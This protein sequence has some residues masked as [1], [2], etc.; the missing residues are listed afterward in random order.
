M[1]RLETMCVKKHSCLRY[2]STVVTLEKVFLDLVIETGAGSGVCDEE[3]KRGS[4]KE[5][6]GE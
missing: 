2:G 5:E 1:E 6:R 3:D 4:R